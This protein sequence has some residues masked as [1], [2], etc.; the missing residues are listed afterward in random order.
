MVMPLSLTA[1]QTSEHGLYAQL[2]LLLSG[3]FLRFQNQVRL[4]TAL[5]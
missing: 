1:Q 4:Q 3:Q 5:R 2:P